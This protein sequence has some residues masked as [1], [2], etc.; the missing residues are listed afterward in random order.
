MTAVAIVFAGLAALLHI[1][2]FVAE[3]VSWRHPAVWRT[4]GV[5]SEVEAKVLSTAM[6]NQGFYN[7]FLALGTVW[8]M[9]L[10]IADDNPV[11]V[12]FCLA[13]MIAAALVLVLRRRAMWRGAL[14]QG[15]MPLL[16]VLAS[17]QVGASA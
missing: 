16:A 10:A 3:S 15:L 17:L 13:M 5:P 14:L 4:F 9:Y 6:F 1:G 12:V 2:F 8:G 7:L 11:L